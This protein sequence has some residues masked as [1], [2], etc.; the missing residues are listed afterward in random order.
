MS[1]KCFKKWEFQFLNQKQMLQSFEKT[2]QS[3]DHEIFL[4]TEAVQNMTS[5]RLQL[6]KSDLKIRK[7]YH[8]ASMSI[9]KTNTFLYDCFTVFE[10][11]DAIPYQNVFQDSCRVLQSSIR[12]FLSDMITDSWWQN[13]MSYDHGEMSLFGIHLFWKFHMMQPFT[14]YYFA[15]GEYKQSFLSIVCNDKSSMFI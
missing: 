10:K 14:G 11:Y 2:V 15:V 6:T 1:P 9:H 12:H 13:D 8:H 4:I 3:F 7:S 5:K